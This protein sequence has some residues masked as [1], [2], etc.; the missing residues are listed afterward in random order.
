[1]EASSSSER[2]QCYERIK[3]GFQSQKNK[4]LHFFGTIE[5]FQRTT[6]ALPKHCSISQNLP[7]FPLSNKMVVF[8][9]VTAFERS[10]IKKIRKIK[11][12]ARK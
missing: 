4:L 6:L 11:A 7:Y 1:M 9:S 2:Q 10:Q 3:G 5:E 12:N 8:N